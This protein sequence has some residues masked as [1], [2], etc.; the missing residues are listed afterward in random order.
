MTHSDLK[1]FNRLAVWKRNDERA[2]HK[3]LLVLWA[4]GRCLQGKKRLVEYQ[5]VHEALVSLLSEFGPARAQHKPYEPFWRLQNDDVWEI[6]NANLITEDSRGGVSPAALREHHIMGGFPESLFNLFCREKTIALNVAGQLL[7]A[8]FPESMHLPVLEATLGKRVI[9]DPWYRAEGS[10][11]EESPLLE[12]RI[13]RRAR[14]FTFRNR[15]LPNY[16]YRCAVCEFSIEFPVGYW[17]AL[18]AAHIK[19]HSHRGPNEASNGLSLCVLHHELFDWGAFTIL[20]ESLE[21]VVAREVVSKSSVESLVEFNGR[22]LSVKPKNHSDWP[23]ADY[24]DWHARNV[25][26]GA[27]V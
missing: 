25:F 7:D 17:P 1:N 23:A 11:S 14:D 24:L 10:Q 3:P 15:I 8:H 13:R 26:K 6:P 5:V 2:P 18:E 12:S 4:I 19:W 22:G 9:Y 20:P 27:A 21:V 16:S